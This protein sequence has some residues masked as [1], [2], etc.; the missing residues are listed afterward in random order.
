MNTQP[1]LAITKSKTAPVTA[2]RLSFA[3]TP[4]RTNSTVMTTEMPKT[5]GSIVEFLALRMSTILSLESSPSTG[6]TEVLR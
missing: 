1:K 2:A 4:Q 5:P 6:E 3:S